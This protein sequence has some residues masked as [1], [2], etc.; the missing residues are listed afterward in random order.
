MKTSGIIILLIGVLLT[1][2]TTFQFFTKEKVVDLG[3]I[4]V[5][6]EKPHTLNWSPFVGIAVIVLGGV[7]LI[8][9]SKK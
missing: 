5:T 2:F 1:I 3:I 8:K 7:L 4:E 9:A 6:R